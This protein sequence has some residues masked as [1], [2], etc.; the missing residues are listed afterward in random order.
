[1]VKMYI[2]RHPEAMGNAARI[3]Q[4]STDCDVTE[5]G[6]RQLGCLSRRFADI[7]LDAIYSSPLKRAYKTAEAINRGHNL[8]IQINDDLREIC[9][10]VVEGLTWQ[11]FSEKMPKLYETWNEKPY[12]FNPPEGESMKSVYNR[13]YS[14]VLKIAAENEGKTVAITSHG[15]TIRNIF[16]RALGYPLEDITAVEWCD[17]TGVSLLILDKDKPPYFEYK[18]DLSHLTEDCMPPRRHSTFYYS[19]KKT[20][21]VSR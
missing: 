20:A 17:N 2:V 12:L 3:F 10:G 9:G 21:G 18:N 14:A 1:M 6:V 19:P 13:A 5:R 15:C 4:G 11:E 7:K 16:C 8:E